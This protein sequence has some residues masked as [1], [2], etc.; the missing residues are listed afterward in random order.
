MVIPGRQRPETKRVSPLQ[1]RMV[2]DMTIRKFSPKTIESY[3][4]RAK[5]FAWH[6]GKSPEVLGRE[7]IR[8]YFL[9]LARE[10]EVSLSTYRIT[11]GALR[12]LYGVTLGREWAIESIPYPRRRTQFNPVVLSVEE[13]KALFAVEMDIKD[14]AML[15]LAYSVGFRFSDIRGLRVED[16]DSKRMLITARH[17]T[18]GDKVR[19]VPL[20]LVLLETLRSYFVA[21]RPKDRMFTRSVTDD[22]PVTRDMF[23]RMCERARVKAGIRRYFSPH[24]LRHTFA[25]HLLESRIDLLTIQSMLG[26]A[27]LQTTAQY[28]KVTA[29][30][31]AAV[32]MALEA[33]RPAS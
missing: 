10:N 12:F 19:R 15:L 7:E 6:Y 32:P 29:P 24:A 13:V 18:K 25:T 8:E 9:F 20:S 27:R 4:H 33:L 21:Y 16:I 2:E 14:R 28:A 5:V 3:V 26:H 30:S 17:G 1:R 11:V 23:A 22:R 31:L